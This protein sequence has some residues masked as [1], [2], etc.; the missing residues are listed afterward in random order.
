M[1]VL[2]HSVPAGSEAAW[3]RLSAA[4]MAGPAVVPCAG[5]GRALWHG[6][7]G[8]QVVAARACLECPV[9]VLCDR[10]ATA[11]AERFGTWGGLT[12]SERREAQ[13]RAQEMTA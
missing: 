3:G 7:A 8:E 1:S 2:A 11:A 12:E 9:M 5:R 6:T 10:Y 4:V 13:R